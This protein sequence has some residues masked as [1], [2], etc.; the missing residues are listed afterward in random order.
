MPVIQTPGFWDYLGQAFGQ[1]GATLMEQRK[2]DRERKRMKVAQIAQMVQSGQMDPEVANKDPDVVAMGFKFAPTPQSVARKIMASPQGTPVQVPD[3][4]KFLAPTGIGSTPT[5]IGTTTMY[6]P[7]SP[8]ERYFSNT[9]SESTIKTDQVAGKIADIKMRLAQGQPVSSAEAALAGVKTPSDLELDRR[10][11][12]DPILKDAATRHV[13]TTINAAKLDTNNPQILRRH[14]AT[15]AKSA[16][17]NYVKESEGPGSIMK[18]SPED[19]AYAKSFFDAAVREQVKQ[20]EEVANRLRLANVGRGDSRTVALFTSLNNTADD[21]YKAV[22]AFDKST[23]GMAVAATPADKL[24][25]NPQL[26]AAAEE[27]RKNLEI[28]AGYR[29]AARDLIRGKLDMAAV[30]SLEAG[31]TTEPSSTTPPPQAGTADLPPEELRNIISG[32]RRVPKSEQASFV[33][34]RKHRLSTKDYMK[35]K[36]ALGLP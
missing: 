6:K 12:L 31:K 14:A 19:K 34:A 11:K 4:S 18:L 2:E 21:I 36:K 13:D 10:S 7:W 25:N 16:Y 26:V 20:A 15:L 35:L 9:P 5:P 3:L 33:E 32:M 24:A 29:K 22:E 1:T 17:E 8:E 28:A 27:R 30:D 23:I